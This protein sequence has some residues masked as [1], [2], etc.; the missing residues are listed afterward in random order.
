MMRIFLLSSILLIK[1]SCV[2]AGDEDVPSENNE[3]TFI[4]AIAEEELFR[5]YILKLPDIEKVSQADAA[6]FEFINQK[7]K[8][9]KDD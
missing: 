6:L 1:A 7:I 3:I 9:E 2:W 4:D 8:W 5:P